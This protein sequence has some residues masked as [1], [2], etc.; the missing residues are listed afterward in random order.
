MCVRQQLLVSPEGIPC[1]RNW[2]PRR[3]RRRRPL[4]S[5]SSVWGLRSGDS[6]LSLSHSRLYVSSP[7]PLED[8]VS[9]YVYLGRTDYRRVPPVSSWQRHRQT[10]Q[11]N[12]TS[13][14]NSYYSKS[15]FWWFHSRSLRP[16]ISPKTD[17]LRHIKGWPESIR[18]GPTRWE[19]SKYRWVKGELSFDRSVRSGTVED[20]VWGRKEELP[21]VSKGTGDWL[22]EDEV[23][24]GPLVNKS[25]DWGGGEGFIQ[26]YET[27]KY[28]CK[29]NRQKYGQS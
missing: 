22:H 16:R 13:V 25:K 5:T 11:N 2:C 27:I 23:S 19:G 15:T 9:T 20:P 1:T 18:D 7:S 3:G 6:R 24:T 4:L 26:K 17:A 29:K 8:L 14:G 10:Q 28:R 12:L 21:E